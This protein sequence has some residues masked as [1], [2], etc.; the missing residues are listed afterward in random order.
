[1]RRQSWLWKHISGMNYLWWTTTQ[2]NNLSFL[3]TSSNLYFPWHRSFFTCGGAVRS[4]G[5]D[6]SCSLSFVKWYLIRYTLCLVPDQVLCPSL[7]WMPDQVLF[8]PSAW[9]GTL[10]A[11]CLIRYS[12]S[13][14]SDQVLSLSLSD[15]KYL[16]RYSICIK[17]LILH[18]SEKLLD[19]MFTP[20]YSDKPYLP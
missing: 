5:P 1:M 13:Q 3:R 11:E 18:S 17:Y 2:S 8:L 19:Q 7:R 10:S 6:C 4:T 20:Q 9:S 12:L 14:V 15:F 16:I